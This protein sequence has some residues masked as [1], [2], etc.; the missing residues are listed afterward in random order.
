MCV[1]F[2]VI[3]VKFLQRTELATELCNCFLVV[4][5]NKLLLLL[6]RTQE[7]PAEGVDP[8]EET[9]RQFVTRHKKPYLNDK[10]GEFL[11]ASHYNLLEIHCTNYVHVDRICLV[12]KILLELSRLSVQ[13][14]ELY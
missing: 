9:F 12:D 5:H 4:L 1:D 14:I 13:H 10:N 2:D 6:L 11:K 3:D 8:V 7:K